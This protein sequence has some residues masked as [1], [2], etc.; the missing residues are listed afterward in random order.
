MK[1][2]GKSLIAV[3]R[4]TPAPAQNQ[5][6]GTAWQ[7]S[8]RISR[9]RSM[10]IWPKK[11][12]SRVGSTASATGNSNPASSQRGRPRRSA[13]GAVSHQAATATATTVKTQ[14]NPIVNPTG[15]RANGRSSR[16]ANGG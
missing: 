16:A 2:P 15:T 8:A 7:K 6:R 5:R 12:V 4:P 13:T 9:I 14:K 11:Y 10:L 3:A 1:I